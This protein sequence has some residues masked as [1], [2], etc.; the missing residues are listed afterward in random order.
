MATTETK[1][2]RAKAGFVLSLIGG[3]LILIYALMVI[4]AGSELT[5]MLEQMGFGDVTGLLNML[6]A[7]GVLSGFL[8]IIGALLIYMPGKEVI[9]GVVVLIFSLLSVLGGGGFYF[10]GTILG[11]I[12][13]ILGIMKK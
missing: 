12:G 1:P 6:L 2:K 3:I 11:I 13:G 9:G 10:I 8:V 5:A 7:L 4:S